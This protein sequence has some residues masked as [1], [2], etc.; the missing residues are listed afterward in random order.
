MHAARRPQ[1]R[2]GG[3]GGVEMRLHAFFDEQVTSRG[4]EDAHV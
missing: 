1:F 4:L 3:V 2:T